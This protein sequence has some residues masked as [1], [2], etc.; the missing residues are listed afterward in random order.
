MHPTWIGFHKKLSKEGKAALLVALKKDEYLY[1]FE[2]HRFMPE[3]REDEEEQGLEG[4]EEGRG[5][6]GA[7]EGDGFGGG[8]MGGNCAVGGGGEGENGDGGRAGR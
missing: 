7:R 8:R 6:T 5:G 2:N 3:E 1:D 4:L